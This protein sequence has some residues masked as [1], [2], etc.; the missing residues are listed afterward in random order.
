MAEGKK[1]KKKKAVDAQEGHLVRG[2]VREGFLE[3]VANKAE[4]RKKSMCLGLILY[5]LCLRA[6]TNQFS[7][8]S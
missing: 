3:D 7:K 8:E 5:F 6:S 2:C 1:K 4:P